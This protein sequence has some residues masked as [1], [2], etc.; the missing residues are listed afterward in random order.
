MGASVGHESLR[1]EGVSK[2]Y[3]RQRVVDRVSLDVSR[4]EIV[5]LLGPNGAGKTTTFRMV[6]GLI[7][8]EEG[9][10]FLDGRE[11]T[12]LPMYRRARMGVG[13]LPQEAS[14]FRGL[15][16]EENVLAILETRRMRRKERKARAQ[17]LLERLQI[18]HLS[19]QG[20]DSLSGGERRRLEITR[21]LA[22]DP[23]YMLLD[24]PFTGIDPKA[25]SEIQGI[26][27]DL[28]DRTGLGFLIT[29]HQVRETLEITDRSYI[30]DH[31]KVFRHGTPPELVVDPEVRRI[32]LGEQFYMRDDAV[33][34]AIQETV[35]ELEPERSA[36]SKEGAEGEVEAVAGG[37]SYAE[38]Q[39]A[40]SEGNEP[41]GETGH[42]REEAVATEDQVDSPDDGDVEVELPESGEPGEKTGESESDAEESLPVEV[43]AVETAPGPS[44][45][46]S[47]EGAAAGTPP[48]DESEQGEPESEIPGE[49]PEGLEEGE[50]R[51]DDSQEQ[52][53]DGK[54]PGATPTGAEQSEDAPREADSGDDGDREPRLWM[55]LE[56]AGEGG[57]AVEE[58]A[59]EHAVDDAAA[60]R[61]PG[62]EPDSDSEVIIKAGEGA[63]ERLP[64]GEDSGE[65]DGETRENASLREENDGEKPENSPRRGESGQDGEPEEPSDGS[66]PDRQP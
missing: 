65:K 56:D 2:S 1:V 58:D 17:E 19:G 31:G 11:I 7:R 32:Y 16:V 52:E 21:A 30:I 61:D 64:D 25:V 54:A 36:S 43:K 38:A 13:Y 37:E 63:G 44:E 28:R 18:A 42:P 50:E 12:R 5:G 60:G 24:E 8:P 39:P 35:T 57:P 46:S 14:I 34:V 45:P 62:A 29:D 48:E 53:L 66:E 47:A 51:G 22:A 3:G 26:V 10:V 20:A 49:R 4:G 59:A 9:E 15:T 6:V 40:A 55:E 33:L 27:R 41:A 23:A